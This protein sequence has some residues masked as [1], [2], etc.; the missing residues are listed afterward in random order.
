LYVSKARQ[1][2]GAV[3]VSSSDRSLVVFPYSKGVTPICRPP[4]G[5]TMTELAT[6]GGED[7]GCTA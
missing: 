2:R 6:L 4:E 5:R 1:A 7:G 3:L